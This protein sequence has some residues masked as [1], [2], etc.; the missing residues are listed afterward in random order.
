MVF[1]WLG[2]QAKFWS[3]YTLNPD[4]DPTE[5]MTRIWTRIQI[6]FKVKNRLN[7]LMIRSFKSYKASHNWVWGTPKNILMLKRDLTLLNELN[8]AQ[9]PLR[10]GSGEK[11]EEVEEWWQG[12]LVV[13]GWCGRRRRD[14]SRF[15]GSA[16]WTSLLQ[17]TAQSRS[18][19]ELPVSQG[20]VNTY[21][22]TIRAPHTY[23]Q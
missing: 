22:R 2:S 15:P 10:V 7:R 3:P 5:V 18:R 8:T 4:P 11:Q 17:D 13:C 16:P 6:F 20:H 9:P 14:F 21:Q 12:W 1:I 23:T 19:V